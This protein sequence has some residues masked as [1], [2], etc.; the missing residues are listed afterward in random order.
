MYKPPSMHPAVY[1][2]VSEC[3]ET[4]G[5]EGQYI[6]YIQQSTQSQHHVAVPRQTYHLL[7]VS[8]C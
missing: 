5:E 7:S 3:E 4:G 6:L 8:V 1:H 2:L